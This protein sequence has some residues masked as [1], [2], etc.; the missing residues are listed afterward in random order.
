MFRKTIFGIFAAAAAAAAVTAVLA[1]KNR[2]NDDVDES[3]DDEDEGIHFIKIEDG[4]DEEE[5][6]E[7]LLKKEPVQEEKE[8]QEEQPS[9][10]QEVLA[11]YPY[12]DADFVK[13]VLSRNDEFNE[14]FEE[15]TLISITHH[16]SFEKDE[17]R[18]T[19]LD[20]LESSGYACE[21]SGNTLAAE[22]KFFVQPGAVISDILNVANQVA[23]LQGKYLDYDLK[24]AA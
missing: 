1:L 21:T 22:R 9:E 20:V 11:V 12:L 24:A 10:V 18:D 16:A 8:E 17:M 14:M 5:E 6:D 19:C 7:P 4:D 23:A 13:S 2:K 3:E 15:D